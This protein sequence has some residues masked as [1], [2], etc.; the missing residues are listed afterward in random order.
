MYYV[1]IVTSAKNE[2]R[3]ISE[4]YARLEATMRAEGKSWRLIIADND[5]RDKTWNIIQDLAL[6]KKNVIGIK[7]ARDF[8]FENAIKAGLDISSSEVAI[9]MASDLQDAPEDIPLFLDKYKEGFNHVYQIVT[10]RPGVPKIRIFNTW[11]FYKIASYLSGGKI[12]KNVG[13]FRLISHEIVEFMS[14]FPERNRFFRAMVNSSDNNSVGVRIARKQRVHGKSKSS[15][16]YAFGLAFRGIILNS[17]GLLDLTSAISVIF[18]IMTLVAE[19]G[20]LVSQLFSAVPHLHFAAGIYFLVAFFGF[21]SFTLGIIS[22][23]ISLIFD[24]VRA[25]PHY[26]IRETVGDS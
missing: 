24:E 20:F 21:T 15:A 23:Y 9:I 18:G 19:S 26:F 5:S 1:D 17:S 25:R 6:E 4:L 8:G 16:Q 11:L 12:V 10:S 13:D 14:K 22:K 3:N 7:M 2:E